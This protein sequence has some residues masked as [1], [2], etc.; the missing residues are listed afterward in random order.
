M[1]KEREMWKRFIYRRIVILLNISA[2]HILN[3]QR[4]KKLTQKSRSQ[5]F[6][7]LSPPFSNLRFLP[8]RLPPRSRLPLPQLRRYNPTNPRSLRR[9]QRPLHRHHVRQD[10]YQMGEETS[11]ASFRGC[12]VGRVLLWDMEYAGGWC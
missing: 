9:V 7:T 2:N 1:G 5:P 11:L 12:A 3:V 6:F 10:T 4:Q 8:K